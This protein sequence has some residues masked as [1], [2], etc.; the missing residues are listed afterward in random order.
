MKSIFFTV[1]ITL[2]LLSGCGSNNTAVE[3]GTQDPVAIEELQFTLN[4]ALRASA[5]NI[6]MLNLEH[7]SATVGVEDT[8]TAGTDCYTY[9][10]D[11]SIQTVLSVDSGSSIGSLSITNKAINEI[12]TV[13]SGEISIPLE[14]SANTDYEVCVTHNGASDQMQTVFVRFT[15]A[16]SASA[17]SSAIASTDDIQPVG[18]SDDDLKKLLAT[19]DCMECDLHQANLSHAALSKAI[20]LNANLSDADLDYADLSSANLGGAN[21]SQANLNNAD[22]P[23]AYLLYAYLHKANLSYADLSSANL[24]DANLTYADL[25]NAD[26][27]A[28]DLTGA[29][30]SNATWTNGYVCKEGSIEYCK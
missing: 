5:D 6:V 16:A 2:V 14:L 4:I 10:H 25:T 17:A 29:D 24:G 8:A 30:L 1:A 23:D 19:N 21:L 22:L 15:D 12:I 13:L 26:L 7:Q 11:K 3:N 20:L 18:Y 27:T 28:A 9:L